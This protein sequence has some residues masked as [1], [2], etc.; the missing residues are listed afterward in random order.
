MSPK[1]TSAMSPSETICEK[2]MSC[3]AAQSMTAV[4]SAPDCD[5]SA[6]DPAFVVRCAKLALRPMLG[7]SR[8]IPFGPSVYVATEALLRHG[9]AAQQSA[10]LPKLA[11]GTAIGTFAFAEKAGQN[12]AESVAATVKD[13]KLSGTKLPVAD[14]A[15]AKLAVVAAKENGATGLYLVDLEGAGVERKALETFDPSRGAASIRFEGARCE[16]L[17]SADEKADLFRRVAARVY[18][19]EGID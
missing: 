19:L 3:P 13:G 12:A 16:K 8:P 15:V 17:A 14:G 6:S 2:P 7:L 4:T 10:W 11:N 5:R 9:S 18:R 1:S